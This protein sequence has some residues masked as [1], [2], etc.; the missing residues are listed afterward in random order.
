MSHDEYFGVRALTRPDAY[1]P[2]DLWPELVIGGWERVHNH[3]V[4]PD[5]RKLAYF[6]DRD[7]VSD[8]WVLTLDGASFPRRLTLNRPHVNWWEDEAPAWSPDSRWLVYGAYD[9]SDVSNLYVVDAAGGAPRQL[10]RLTEDAS[11]PRFSP[12]G[13]Y[14][15]FSTHQGEAGQIAM[16]PFE[17]GWVIGLTF[18]E[19]ECSAPVWSPDG[20]RVLYSASPPRGRRQNDIFAI[21][22]GE[23][24]V[25]GAAGEPEQLTPD[26]DVECWWPS[27]APDGSHI[28][29]LSNRSGFDEL[30]LM[31]ADGSRLAQ[32]SRLNLDIEE[33]D[34]A[35]DG[36]SLIALVNERGVDTLYRIDARNGAATRLPCPPG[37]YSSVRCA[38]GGNDVIVAYD[39]PASPPALYRIQTD[40]GVM[41]PLTN[42]SAAAL[43]NASFVTPRH[44]EFSSADGWQIPGFL[45]TPP[46]K[47]SRERGPAIVY[48]HGG[49]NAHYD[50]AW[51]PVRQYF[52]AKGYTILCPNFRGST[53]YGRLFKEGNIGNW[54]VGD[55]A[56]CLAAADYLAAL[57]GVD[58]AR[59]AIWGQS[60]GGY[61]CTLALGKDPRRRFRC[62]VDLF[63][64]S[65]LKT[66]WATGD[67]SGRQDLEWQMGTPREQGARYESSSPLN[68]VAHIRAPMLIL[69]GEQDQRVALSESLQLVEALK[70]HGAT[71]EFHSYPDEGH[72][73][74]RVHNAI[75][76]L[77]RVERF[78]DWWLI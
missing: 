3:A 73:F 62:G 27:F 17:G 42:A 44:I 38:P 65:H 4:S 52:T 57:P 28:A 59:I 72:G 12:D 56:D 9:A 18:G 66:A 26:D 70:R 64:D 2:D 10:T 45:Y 75:D 8:L 68:Y 49:P 5:G 6:W 58:P 78:L 30:W 13:R 76:A 51:D 36:A 24:S 54:G 34:W 46:A 37:N 1:S 50:L 22:I 32:L 48:P 61:L 7:G 14:I 35:P 15:V 29:L 74:A 77:K 63:G 19:Q 41:L 11:E 67:H 53:G 16:V 40:T 47:A 43:D 69:H 33:Y 39:A 21:T 55:L 23:G 31:A 71:F 25:R 60:Y 20:A